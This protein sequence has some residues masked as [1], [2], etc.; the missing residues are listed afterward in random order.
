MDINIKMSEKERKKAKRN[1]W[2]IKKEIK[3]NI[4]STLRA[5]R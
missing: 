5:K 4:N 3:F 2:Q 1:I